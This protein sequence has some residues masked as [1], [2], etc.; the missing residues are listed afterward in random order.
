MLH[1]YLIMYEDCV[2]VWAKLDESQER[3]GGEWRADY[4]SYIHSRS[5]FVTMCVVCVCACVCVS[6]CVCVRVYTRMCM[7]V[8]MPYSVGV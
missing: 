2:Y 1:I 3:D 7:G 4:K 8:C 6:V 5:L